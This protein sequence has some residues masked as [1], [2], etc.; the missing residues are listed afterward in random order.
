MLAVLTQA[1][2]LTHSDRAQSITLLA[3][4]MGLP[5]AVIAS[6]LDHRPPTA[7]KPLGDATIAAQQK[8]ADLFFANRLVPVQVDISQRVWHPAAQ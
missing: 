1:D 2:A 8:T 3:K 5:E 7:I 4:A 6:Y